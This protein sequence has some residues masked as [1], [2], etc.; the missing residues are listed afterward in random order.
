LPRVLPS[1]GHFLWWIDV[2]D[3]AAFYFIL[4]S[5][6]PSLGHFPHGLTSLWSFTLSDGCVLVSLYWLILLRERP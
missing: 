2:K 6:L 3:A 4:S 1:L 5:G